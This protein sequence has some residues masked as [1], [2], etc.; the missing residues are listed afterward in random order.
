MEAFDHGLFSSFFSC[1]QKSRHLSRTHALAGLNSGNQGL[2]NPPQIG[3]GTG[4]KSHLPPGTHTQTLPAEDFTASIV[5]DIRY[6]TS[7]AV[8]VPPLNLRT[9]HKRNA[10]PDFRQKNKAGT[11][12]RTSSRHTYTQLVCEQYSV[13]E[14]YPFCRKIHNCSR[15]LKTIVDNESARTRNFFFT[16]PSSILNTNTEEELSCF[17]RRRRRRGVTRALSPYTCTLTH[18]GRQTA[19]CTCRGLNRVQI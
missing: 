11:F 1:L 2:S 8:G 4:H 13:E 14:Y 7:C 17:T 6:S 12:T 16:S 19:T 9:I 3:T 10:L 5:C 15:F 18:P